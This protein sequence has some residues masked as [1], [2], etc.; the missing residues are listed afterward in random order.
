[1]QTKSDVS[2]DEKQE[3]LVLLQARLSLL[4]DVHTKLRKL[5][6]Y[7]GSIAV[8]DKQ[9]QLKV[10]R[11][12]TNYLETFKEVPTGVKPLLATIANELVSL[13]EGIMADAVQSKDLVLISGVRAVIAVTDLQVVALAHKARIESQ[14][15]VEGATDENEALILKNQK[16]KAAIPKLG[17]KD[18]VVARAPV[19]F[20][21]QQKNGHSSVGYV[22]TGSIASLGFKVDN[23]GGYT[24]LYDQLLV[25]VNTDAVFDV[26]SENTNGKT[27]KTRQRVSENAI[28]FKKGTPTKVV[29]RRDKD[30][31]DVALHVKKQLEKRTNQPY[32]FVSETPQGHEGGHWFWLMPTRDLNRLARA[33]PGGHAKINRWGFAF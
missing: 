11:S 4:A 24:V 10:L 23:L 31:L 33:F 6:V 12:A 30:Y 13:R 17:S 26:S 19:A 27:V 15:N 5:N 7:L 1:M 28:T 22:D 8:S 32:A 18:F 25:G 3:R 14:L 20:T 29:K 2:L 16:F 9:R 21:F